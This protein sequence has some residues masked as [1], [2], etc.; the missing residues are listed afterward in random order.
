MTSL[1]E[2][3]LGTL[4]DLSSGDLEQFKHVAQYMKMKEV[5]P[6]I[7]RHQMEMADGRDEIVELMVKIYGQQCVEVTRE[8]LKKLNRTD[9][10]ER[11]SDISSGSKEGPS[12]S[13][14]LKGCGSSTQDSSDWTKLEPEVNS[15][16]ADEVSSYSLQTEAGKFECS[17]S[18]L[19]WFCK[20]NVS[21]KYQFCSWGEPMERMESIQYMPAGPLIDITV[22]AGRLDEMHLPHWICIDDPA[23]LDKFAVLHINDSGDVVEKVSE[24]TQSHVKLS[25]PIFS[26]RAVLMKIGFPLKI[27]CNVLI[28]YKPNTPFLK[29]HVYLIPHDLALKTRVDE[30]E[31]SK[32]YQL[33]EKPRPDK[34]LKMKQG[35]K[36]AA[37]IDTARIYPKEITLRYDSQEP[38]FYEVVSENPDRDF[39]LILSHTNES[40]PVWTCEIQKDD[41]LRYQNSAHLQVQETGG[42]SSLLGLSDKKHTVNEHLSALMQ[43]ATITTD[44]ERLWYV[45]GRLKQ[46][47]FKEF[48]WFL[49]DSDILAG[50]PCIPSC[51]LEKGEMLDLVD[52]IWQTYSE[53]SVEVTKKVFKKIN[54][55]DLVQMLSGSKA[56]GSSA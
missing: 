12:R 29:L 20:E 8:V 38:N 54:R 3:L 37:D 4:E 27:S 25:E 55:N 6:R 49:Q 40:D 9:L 18:G 1:F 15:T 17:V 19:R 39:H 5:L 16:D 50:L 52:L 23:V 32:G 13:L 42:Q 33:I 11:L 43:N 51:R 22:I 2:K 21:F 34:Y 31:S 56:S 53:H 30:K 14:E 28:Y 41:D 48:K 47:E 24:V 35:F 46:E 36:L 7:P 45:L 44:R 10:V 26:P